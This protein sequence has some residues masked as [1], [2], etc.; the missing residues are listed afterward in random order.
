M[1]LTNIQRTYFFKIFFCQNPRQEHSL[2][3][4]PQG[5]GITR[6]IDKVKKSIF[7]YLAALCG[8]LN[9]AAA[10]VVGGW[11]VGGGGG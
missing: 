5:L 2:K 8:A 4:T 7:A 1:P 10:A 6:H 9:L 3:L 11:W